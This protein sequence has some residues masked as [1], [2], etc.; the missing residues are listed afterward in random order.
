MR[1]GTF[2]LALFFVATPVATQAQEPARPVAPFTLPEEKDLPRGPLG[3]FCASSCEIYSGRPFQS[4]R[5]TVRMTKNTGIVMLAWVPSF[6]VP[7]VFVRHVISWWQLLG[8]RWGPHPV[9]SSA[10]SQ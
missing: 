5:W 7:P 9:A 1:L 10:W 8:R 4:G 2:F 3:K 6:L